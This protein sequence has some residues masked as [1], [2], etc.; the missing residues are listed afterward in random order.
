MR[1]IRKPF[2]RDMVVALM[3]GKTQT[4]RKGKLDAHPGDIIAVTEAWW[5]FGMWTHS[6]KLTKTGKLKRGWKQNPSV[7]IIYEA[8]HHEG[9]K[10]AQVNNEVGFWRK[11]PSIHL[12]LKYS[13]IFLEVEMSWRHKLQDMTED[14]ALDEGID[15]LNVPTGGDDYYDYYR[16]YSQP[17]EGL[18]GWPWISGDPIKSYASLWDSINGKEEYAW[19]FNPEVSC[20]Q[21]KLPQNHKL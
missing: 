11:M 8:D 6:D 4:R 5:S 13:R 15:W 3:K 7:P 21:F 16:D 1:Y 14:D 17:K 12:P 9:F 20:Y 18:D 2:N 19:R 10:P